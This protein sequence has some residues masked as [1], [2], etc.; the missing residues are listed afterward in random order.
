MPFFR[1][2]CESTPSCGFHTV[3]NA[4]DTAEAM[5][6]AL[7]AH[8]AFNATCSHAEMISPVDEPKE[9]TKKAS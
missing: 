3:L 9:S 1:V 5:I 2:I 8:T 7:E 6:K 4:I